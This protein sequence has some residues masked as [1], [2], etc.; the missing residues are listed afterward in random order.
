MMTLQLFNMVFKDELHSQHAVIDVLYIISFS[1][2][3]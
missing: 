1:N 2:K 3:V